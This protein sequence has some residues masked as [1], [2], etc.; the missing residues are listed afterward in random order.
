MTKVNRKFKF[1]LEDFGNDIAGLGSAYLTFGSWLAL[2]VGKDYAMSVEVDRK[3][4]R[5]PFSRRD[6]VSRVVG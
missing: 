3:Q 1:D 6:V 4:R 2:N 5:N